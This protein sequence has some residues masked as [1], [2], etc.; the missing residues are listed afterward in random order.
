[1][2]LIL[3]RHGQ[4]E[5]NA[6]G[7]IQG[8]MP[9][10]LT[11]QGKNQAKR[12][13]ERLRK[14]KIDA[15]YSSDLKRAADTA[16]QIAKHQPDA[17]LIF[18]KKLRERDHGS[19]SGKNK[20]E[21][22]WEDHK[23][24]GE[25]KE[26]MRTRVKKII[27]E[28]YSRYKE[29]VVV[30]V[31]HGAINRMFI[32]TIKGN[33]IENW[34]DVDKPRNTSVSIFEIEEDED[35]KI[36]LLNCTKHLELPSHEQ[37][38]AWYRELGTPDN[39]IEHVKTVNKVATFLAKKLMEKGIEIDYGLVDRASL[40][41]DLDKWK[42]IQDKTVKHGHETKRILTEKGFPR[43]GEYAKNHIPKEVYWRETEW[44]ERLIAYADSRVLNHDIVP[45]K[46]RVDYALEKYN[47]P[48][49]LRKIEREF[50]KQTENEIF[51]K[52]DFE[53]EDLKKEIERSESTVSLGK[54]RAP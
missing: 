41:H 31:A 14:Q 49:E 18:T 8:H 27:D 6:K 24:D 11:E 40:L 1:M 9:G 35:H 7:I 26:E 33:P 45:Q 16:K 25:T 39:I 4:T 20:N 34:E 10:K 22:N 3:T 47:F 21:V 43:I 42:S 44:E 5:E 32:N 17:K 23:Y 29:G 12:L 50:G 38:L 15:I 19:L 54:C 13:A 48:P 51:S 28:A 37:C 46:K 53:P 30:F 52:L 36:R 2:K